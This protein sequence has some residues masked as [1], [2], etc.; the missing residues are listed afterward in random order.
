MSVARN[1]A[2]I[3][4][5]LWNRLQ[6]LDRGT[7]ARLQALL[8]DRRFGSRDRRLYRELLLTAIRYARVLPG[9]D[10]ENWSSLLAFACAS[11]R[12]TTAFREAYAGGPVDSE[13]RISPTPLELMPDWFT[14]ELDTGQEATVAATALLA[15]AP[16]WVRLQTDD[17]ATVLAELAALGLKAEP[18]SVLPDAWRLPPESAVTASISYQNGYYEI[19]DLG[20]Q[21][22]LAS[23][24]LRPADRP[25]RWLDFCA[26]AGGKTL[27]LGRLLGPQ[28]RIEATD[29]RPAA[30]AELRA[31]ALRARLANV[32]TVPRPVGHYDGVLVDAPCSGSGT[33]RRSPHLM[34][35]TGL[36]DL[37]ASAKLQAT[38][39]NE[40]S[41][42]VAPGG[43][44]I[45]ATCSIFR[46]EN[47]D[48]SAAFLSSHSDQFDS[49]A[50]ALDFGFHSFAK[51]GA[52]SCGL[53]L[54]PGVFDNDGFYVAVFR[55]RATLTL[56][57]PVPGQTSA[58]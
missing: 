4:R 11:T 53:R 36:A 49:V 57:E 2:R 16:V 6:P 31:R 41:S 48:V 28:A 35:C 14:A 38:I 40:A 54:A 7:P 52:G 1:Q 23:L 42:R 50:P 12:E 29:I 46:R 33:W 55:R 58:S 3:V 44:L 21:L 20:S 9:L 18:H 30:L 32:Y 10:D 8:S 47:R 51:D 39:L 22:I 24:D 17:H 45:Y 43:L 56:P 15:R 34:A 13:R 19:Q 27:Q 25:V 5:D 26:G 37:D